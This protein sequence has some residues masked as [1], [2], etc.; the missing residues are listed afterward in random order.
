MSVT[1]RPVAQGDEASWRELFLAYGEFYLTK[2]SPE[3]LDGVWAWLMDSDHPERCFVA[4]WDGRVVGFAHLQ[5]QVDTFRSG[6]GWFLDDLY[7]EP[8]HRGKGVARALITALSD[9][10]RAHGGGDLRWITAADNTPAQRLYD[11]IATKTSW[12]MYELDTESPS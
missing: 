7:V 12:V 8:E 6:P 3:I 5:Q 9:Y 10:A 1:I 11:T 2:F 4:E